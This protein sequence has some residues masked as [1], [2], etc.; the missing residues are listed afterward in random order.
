[1]LEIGKKKKKGNRL[2]NAIYHSSISN[3]L[4]TI[5]LTVEKCHQPLMAHPA[6]KKKRKKS[7]RGGGG[8][9]G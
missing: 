4:I 1:M 5:Q 9:A 8:G 2:L 6:A 7:G 3:I